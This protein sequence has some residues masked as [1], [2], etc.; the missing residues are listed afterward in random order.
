VRNA[1][2]HDHERFTQM[3]ESGVATSDGIRQFIVGTGGG[4]P[5]G[6]FPDAVGALR[7]PPSSPGK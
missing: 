6:V 7:A 5:V 1:H 2:D 3:N 4:W